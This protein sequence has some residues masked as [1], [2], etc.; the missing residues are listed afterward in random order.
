MWICFA[1]GKAVG[2]RLWC[3]GA[4]LAV[5]VCSGVLGGSIYFLRC[6]F[7]ALDAPNPASLPVDAQ[8]AKAFLK[9][10]RNT[11]LPYH[12]ISTSH[13]AP[14][15]TACLS[16]AL[17]FAADVPRFVGRPGIVGPIHGAECATVH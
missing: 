14:P 4:L 16:R 3:V 6:S 15:R 2:L 1:R 9:A 17:A 12:I 10:R 5:N 13:G 7:Y 8:A 11:A